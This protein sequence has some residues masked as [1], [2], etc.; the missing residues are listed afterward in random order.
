MTAVDET[1]E[2]AVDDT[3]DAVAQ[4]P[5]EPSVLDA[6]APAEVAYASWIS[7]AGAFVL[8]VLFGLAVFATATLVWFAAPVWGWLWWLCVAVA[9]V[10]LVLVA[11]NRWWLPTATGW[12]LGR[13]AVGI[14]V[15]MRDGSPP[16]V[17]RL[18]A[19]DVLHLLDTAALLVGWLW[20]LFDSRRR[21]FADLLAR[22]EVRRSALGRDMRRPAAAMTMAAMLLCA[23]L[24]ALSYLT[25]Y[26]PVQAAHDARQQ[27]SDQGPAIVTDMLSYS[28]ASLQ[29]DFTRAQSLVTDSYRPQLVSQQQTVEQAIKKVGPATNEYWVASSSVL[30]ASPDQASMLMLMQGQRSAGKQPPRF[31]SATVRVKFDKSSDGKWRVADL[32]PLT[33]PVQPEQSNPAPPEPP[34]PGPP[35]QGK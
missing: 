16:S 5:T 34:K 22:T 7:R 26:R 15:V 2:D 19:R 10:S 3:E 33:K 24:A 27:I 23:V 9:A 29:A 11:V 25:I 21:T 18:M 30:S 1:V 13:A 6:D 14:V 35:K 31:I 17:F 28:A 12:S 8:D 4:D 20:P 32:T